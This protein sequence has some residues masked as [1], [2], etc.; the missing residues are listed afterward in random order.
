MCQWGSPDFGEP[1]FFVRLTGRGHGREG[2]LWTGTE[3]AGQQ[4]AL[5]ETQTRTNVFFT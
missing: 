5:R 4:H 1:H 2:S 3:A